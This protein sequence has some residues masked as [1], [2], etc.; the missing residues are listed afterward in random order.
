MKRNFFFWIILLVVMGAVGYILRKLGVDVSPMILGLVLGKSLEPSL[1]ESLFLSQ[2]DLFVFLKRPISLAFM[3]ASF[4]ML[5][6][7]LFLRLVTGLRKQR[8]SAARSI[9]D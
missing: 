7:P 4:L 2:G 5:V 9:H 1:M 3:I 8:R 6:L